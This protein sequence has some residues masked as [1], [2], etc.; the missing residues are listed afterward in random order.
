MYSDI[1]DENEL[2]YSIKIGNKDDVI[3]LFKTIGC[4]KLNS[5]YIHT[6][7]SNDYMPDFIIDVIKPYMDKGYE[8]ALINFLDGWID[9]GWDNKISLSKKLKFKNIIISFLRTDKIKLDEFYI[10]I[11]YDLFN[12]SYYA[13][14]MIG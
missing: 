2:E 3:S 6:A 4:T 1:E 11:L 10:P 14:T 9:Y 5:Y 7:M 13:E 12:I 8:S